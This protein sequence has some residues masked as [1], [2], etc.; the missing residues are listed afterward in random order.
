MEKKTCL[1]PED[2]GEVTKPINN[3]REKITDEKIDE[4]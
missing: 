1:S 4:W 2:V 3:D